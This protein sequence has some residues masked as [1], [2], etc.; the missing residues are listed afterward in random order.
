MPFSINKAAKGGKREVA[1][2]GSQE[3]PRTSKVPKVSEMKVEPPRQVA[4]ANATNAP[5]NIVV[6]KAAQQQMI[7]ASAAPSFRMNRFKFAP[8][9][10]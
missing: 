4:R 6:Y 5:V 3:Q 7:K 10:R 2:G 8:G 1:D 9:V